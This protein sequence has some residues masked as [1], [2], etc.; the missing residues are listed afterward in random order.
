MD[1]KPKILSYL[2]KRWPCI[3]IN[4]ECESGNTPLHAAVNK[5]NLKL[6][7]TLLESMEQEESTKVDGKKSVKLNV[8]KQNSKCMN[9][10]C[11]HLAVWSDLNEIAIKLVQSGADP[12][13][14]MNGQSTAFDLAKENSNQVLCDLLLEYYSSKKSN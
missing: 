8:N 7:Q 11:L 12:F 5:G 3:D 9:V 2:V 1:E 6:V 10:T 4:K 14:K 13:L